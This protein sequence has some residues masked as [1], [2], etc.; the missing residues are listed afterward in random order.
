MAQLRSHAQKYTIHLCKKYNI[1]MKSKRKEC[2]ITHHLNYPYIRKNENKVL[3]IEK[4]NNQEKFFLKN[5][6]FYNKKIDFAKVEV[7][8]ESSIF[9]KTK[10][11]ESTE[12]NEYP[13][14]VKLYNCLNEMRDYNNNL[15]KQMKLHIV[16]CI[17]IVYNLQI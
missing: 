10:T 9:E 8:S 16:E 15:L 14:F 1:E 7:N 5:F 11:P 6:N 17:R 2:F 13:T 3:P 4:M 12:D